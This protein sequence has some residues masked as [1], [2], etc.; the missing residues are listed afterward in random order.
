M[1]KELIENSKKWLLLIEQSIEQLL[2]ERPQWLRNSEIAKILGLE[3]K[4]DGKQSNYL[5]YSV[6]GIL[7]DKGKVYKTK[8]GNSVI[9]KIA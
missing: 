9:Y 7:M 3:S 4:H 1:T 5:T 2:I 8:I 6:L